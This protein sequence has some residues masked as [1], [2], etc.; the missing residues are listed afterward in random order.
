[1]RESEQRNLSSSAAGQ[2][3]DDEHARL[4]R[5]ECE[6]AMLLVDGL[7]ISCVAERPVLSVGTVCTHVKYL[8]RKTD[9]HDVVAFV[10][11]GND[12]VG[13]CVLR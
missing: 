9:T 5:R 1:M 10:G 11:W 8:H 13:C 3:M 2:D 6:V 7:S 12:H 4:T